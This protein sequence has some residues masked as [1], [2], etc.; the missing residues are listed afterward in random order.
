MGRSVF[1]GWVTFLT[2]AACGGDTTEPNDTI[3]ADA[4]SY[5][6]VVLGIMQ[7][8]SINRFTIDW[9]EFR[10]ATFERAGS[11]QTT[12]DTYPAILLA[13]EMLGDGHSFFLGAASAAPATANVTAALARPPAGHV[14]RDVFGYI[15]VPAFSGSVQQADD[16]AK[17]LQNLIETN[18]APE[19]CGWLVD[20]RHN[21]GGNMWPMMAGVGPVL[22]EGLAGFFVDP[23]PNVPSHPWGYDS[24]GSWSGS[25]TVTPIDDPYKLE[26][27]NPAVAVLTDELTA[28]SGEAVTIAF[29][30]R[31]KTRSFGE[32]TL[33]L[34]TANQGFN[35][36]DG[37]RLF[38]TTST[39][40]DRTET[41]YGG[42]VDPDQLA[43]TNIGSAGEIDPT[44]GDDAAVEAALDW[45][46]A[47]GDCPAP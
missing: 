33:G 18:D 35:L 20:L 25:S 6:G 40:A 12:A 39:M 10:R 1:F 16:L 46:Q 41:L 36:R 14:L 21:T 9:P 28:S 30:E 37:A 27:P 31:P 19:R 47:N 22:G 42:P 17:T 3:S 13:I 43:V 24:A 4:E 26:T 5:L 23:D 32:P 11:A 34:S 8:N 15:Y 44:R 38:L 45:L 2:V 7:D 29:R